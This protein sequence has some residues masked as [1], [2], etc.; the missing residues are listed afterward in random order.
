MITAGYPCGVQEDEETEAQ[1][2]DVSDS[3]DPLL[4][5]QVHVHGE[6]YVL[7]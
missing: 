6:F 2:G 4:N 1:S 5:N 7:E 3:L